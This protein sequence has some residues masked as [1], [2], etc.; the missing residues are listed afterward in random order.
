M[1]EPCVYL[2]QLPRETDWSK[3]SSQVRDLKGIKGL[4]FDYDTYS[5]LWT[6][7]TWTDGASLAAQRVIDDTAT[8]GAAVGSTS[9]TTKQYA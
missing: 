8:L 6:I 2:V 5:R 7:V 9:L 3:I 1:T 4:H